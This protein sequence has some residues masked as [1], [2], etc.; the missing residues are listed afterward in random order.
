MGKT[1]TART[2]T[3]QPGL[4]TDSWNTLNM[5][6]TPFDGETAGEVPRRLCCWDVNR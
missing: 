5:L 3:E 6:S 1:G 4:D 2:K